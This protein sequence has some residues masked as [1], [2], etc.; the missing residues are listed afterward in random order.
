MNHE[1]IH[2]SQCLQ[3]GERNVFF[4][5]S[6]LTDPQYTCT[7]LFLPRL[8][9]GFFSGH[10][11]PVHS[12]LTILRQTYQDFMLTDMYICNKKQLPGFVLLVLMFRCSQDFSWIHL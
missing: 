6:R 9:R 4:C 12:E 10:G 11:S 5:N 7:V 3:S 1:H 8:A 2:Q